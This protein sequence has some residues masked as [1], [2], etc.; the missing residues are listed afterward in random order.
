MVNNGPDPCHIF[1]NLKEIIGQD[2][3][4][5]ICTQY[6]TLTVNYFKLVFRHVNNCIHNSPSQLVHLSDQ[7]IDVILPV[8]MITSFNKVCCLLPVATTSITEFE[9]PEEIISLLKVVSNSVDLVDQIL[10]TDDAFTTKALF[11][12]GII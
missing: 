2:F 9:W 6:G 7:A 11:N 1:L 12:D 8:A 10:H 3:P 4:Q 5:T